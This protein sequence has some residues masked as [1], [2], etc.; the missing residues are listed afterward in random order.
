MI[1]LTEA[2]QKLATFLARARYEFNR[3]NGVQENQQSGR[4]PVMQDRDA[5]GAELAFCRKHNCYPDMRHDAPT[6]GPDALLFAD[7]VDVK[8]SPQKKYMN[9]ARSCERHPF[10]WYVAVTGKFPCYEIVA[11]LARDEVFTEENLFDC[12]NGPYYRVLI[13]G[14]T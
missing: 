2:E 11:L 5:I 7:T 13:E 12:G 9:V 8:Y 6:A 4:D 14:R 3:E 10:D 1:E